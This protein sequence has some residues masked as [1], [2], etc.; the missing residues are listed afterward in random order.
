MNE[1]FLLIQKCD[2]VLTFNVNSNYNDGQAFVNGW[3]DG[4]TRPQQRNIIIEMKLLF[5][6]QSTISFEIDTPNIIEGEAILQLL[7]AKS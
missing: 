7:N 1:I 3:G 6:D 5:F 2:R 4:I